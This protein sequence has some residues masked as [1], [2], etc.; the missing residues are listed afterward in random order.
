MARFLL[1]LGLL[2]L[3]VTTSGKSQLFFEVEKV[4]DAQ[5]KVFNVD[6][7]EDADFYIYF[8]NT[9]E[10]VTKI[11]LWM[12][13]ETTK[14]AQIQLIFVDDE[15]LADFKVCA[16]DDSS[17]AGWKNSNDPRKHLLNL[18]PPLQP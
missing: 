1:S 3:L 8:V 16:V 17:K 14:E 12:E 5:V 18:S 13:V 10:E 11:G 7:A 4:E 2:L 9:K 6:K 15:K